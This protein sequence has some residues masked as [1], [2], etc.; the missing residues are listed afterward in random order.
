MVCVSNTVRQRGTRALEFR[1]VLS[2]M[3][4]G[5]VGYPPEFPRM[6]VRSL[7]GTNWHNLAPLQRS[8]RSRPLCVSGFLPGGA[9]SVTCSTRLTCYN[10]A[11]MNEDD[12]PQA[13]PLEHLVGTVRSLLDRF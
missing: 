1:P 3:P 9:D 6:C 8:P 12:V 11:A 5:P 13:A 2:F 10:R 4:C 7:A